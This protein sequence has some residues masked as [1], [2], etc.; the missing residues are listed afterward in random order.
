MKFLISYIIEL[1]QSII[2]CVTPCN[3][4][5]QAQLLK[6]VSFSCVVC[7]MDVSFILTQI[8]H[9]EYYRTSKERNT[10]KKY[11]YSLS[12]E[13]RW[14]HWEQKKCFC[15]SVE[16]PQ[17]FGDLDRLY[18]YTCQRAL[19]AYKKCRES[20][21]RIISKNHDAI[22]IWSISSISSFYQW[23]NKKTLSHT[24][25]SNLATEKMYLN[26]SAEQKEESFSSGGER[27]KS[28]YWIHNNGLRKAA[29]I[30]IWMCLSIS[31]ASVLRWQWM[32]GNEISFWSHKDVGFV[33]NI[34]IY[35]IKSPKI[36]QRARVTH[37]KIGQG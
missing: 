22:Y 12:T 21:S 18:K 19:N 14:S 17:C 37:Q 13:L 34:H 28:V 32:K 29:K 1:C 24:T 5:F 27:L 2:T 36:T 33:Y 26:I 3:N 7:I 30:T 6:R 25:E 15:K 8:Q 35:A 23:A 4:C 10:F 11:T 20:F 9:L 16:F 31:L